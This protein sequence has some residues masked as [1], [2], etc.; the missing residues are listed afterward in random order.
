MDIPG[1]VTP[2]AVMAT[3]VIGVLG[4]LLWVKRT[5]EQVFV[6]AVNDAVRPLQEA[7][8]RIETDLVE[9]RSHLARITR[10][11]KKEV[12]S[13]FAEVRTK[14]VMVQAQVAKGQEVS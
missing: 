1:T 3:S 14:L 11:R 4:G 5:A 9:D 7:V 13:Q 6:R 12:D 8:D 10:E 2:W